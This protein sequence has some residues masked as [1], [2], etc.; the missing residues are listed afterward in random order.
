MILN[1]I[2]YNDILDKLIDYITTNCKNI[3]DYDGMDKSYKNG[4]KVTLAT[5]R[6]TTANQS[7]VPH[8]LTVESSITKKTIND[9]TNDIDIFF[10]ELGLLKN[11]RDKYITGYNFYNFLYDLILFCNF[12]V[13]W[14]CAQLPTLLGTVTGTSATTV[15]TKADSKEI[16]YSDFIPTGGKIIYPYNDDNSEALITSNNILIGTDKSN[17]LNTLELTELIEYVIANGVGIKNIRV[18]HVGSITKN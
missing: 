18:K 1:T 8:Y 4:T 2:T 7:T 10:S 5:V 12:K 16:V 17:T 3:V 13:C 15:A 11:D 14:A 9:V 6:A